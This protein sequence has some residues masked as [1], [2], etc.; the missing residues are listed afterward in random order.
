MHTATVTLRAADFAGKMSEMRIWLDQHLFEPTRFT[1]KQDRERIV[2]T[3]DFQDGNHAEAFQSHFAGGQREADASLRSAR[4]LL[5]RVSGK[6]ERRGTM[7]QACWW[8][9]VAEEIRVEA[10]NF[11]SEAAKET[12]EIAAR[13]WEQLA[14]DLEHRLARNSRQEWGFFR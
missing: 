4:E 10:D 2:L 1:Y 14:E 3:V 12:M 5:N 9:L 8:R 11:G 13:G 6:P 7:A